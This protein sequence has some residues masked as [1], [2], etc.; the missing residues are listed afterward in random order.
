MS[1]VL[2]NSRFDV[3]EIG[4]VLAAVFLGV[5]PGQEEI[6]DAPGLAEVASGDR[7]QAPRASSGE[8]SVLHI[9]LESRGLQG[10]CDLARFLAE[11]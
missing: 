3:P 4:R 10:L 11:R 9:V 5:V 7:A 8:D 6:H 1:F 2:G